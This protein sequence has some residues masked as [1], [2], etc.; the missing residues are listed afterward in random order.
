MAISSLFLTYS[1]NIE[2]D[3]ASAEL[4]RMFV[5]DLT[6]CYTSDTV[7]SGLSAS[8]TFEPSSSPWPKADG[9]VSL[10]ES[11]SGNRK[12]IA[13][14]Y[15]RPQEGIH[16]LLTAI[17]QAQGYIHKGYNAA[18]IVVPSEYSTHDDPAGFVASVLD[19]SS[20]NA[21]IG[22]FRYDPPDLGNVSPFRGRLHCVRRLQLTSQDA[23]ISSPTGVSTQWV[24]M[25][26]GSTTR[27]AFFRFLQVAKKFSADQ[28]DPVPAI[29]QPLRDAVAK[30]DPSKSA[31]FY[32]SNTA[33]NKPLSRIWRA[34]WF[35][36]IASPA[37]LTLWKKTGSKYDVPDS[38]TKVLR[39][40][41][42]GCSQT[43]EGRASS[44]KNVIVSALNAG[45]INEDT[46]WEWFAEGMRR[47]GSQKTQGI[48][49][50]AHSYREDLDSSLAQLQWIDAD[51]R[52]T[53]YGYHYIGL[54]ERYG[55]ANSAAAT[56]YVGATLLQSG[57]YAA[58]L[59]YVHRL[60]SEYF[61]EDPLKFTAFRKGVP[62]FNDSSYTAYLNQLEDALSEDLKVMRKVSGRARPRHRTPF[63]AELTLLRR[64]GFVSLKRF[65]LGVGIPIDW[66]KV[67]SAMKIEL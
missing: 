48:R 61:E 29:P 22:V 31:E 5:E 59:H 45:S 34:F 60:S 49:A 1:H 40:D 62:I 42:A 18:A 41:G 54:C 28:S 38:F 39:D 26:E 6:L 66:E 56:E 33:D 27:D 32:L 36:W 64:Y 51:G 52:P 53:D 3:F 50:R 65:R 9:L 13:V 20:G 12:D 46:A 67:Q 25:R 23:K 43:F 19:H 14:E 57:R 37:V 21:A 17:G 16:G 15:K 4:A 63:Q 7:P 47:R 8:A 2:A 58:F 55:G 10:L 44:L 35:E 24:H 11:S 30:L